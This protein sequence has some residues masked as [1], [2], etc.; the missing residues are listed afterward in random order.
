MPQTQKTTLA[1]ADAKERKQRLAHCVKW[2]PKGDLGTAYLCYFHSFVDKAYVCH[3]QERDP[4]VSIN[5]IDVI[6]LKWYL[7]R[8]E[9]P[10]YWTV[11]AHDLEVA[12]LECPDDIPDPWCE[13]MRF[14]TLTLSLDCFGSGFEEIQCV[15]LRTSCTI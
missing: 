3:A 6:N 15:F 14:K 4:T 13:V 8:K 11:T 9:D 10:G 5:Y 12:S 1:N 7:D 2:T